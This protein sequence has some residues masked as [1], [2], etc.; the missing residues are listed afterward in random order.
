MDGAAVGLGK[1]LGTC[2]LLTYLALAL[3]YPKFQTMEHPSLASQG[4]TTIA[5]P[6]LVGGGGR[7]VGVTKGGHGV[8]GFV[9]RRLPWIR[10]SRRRR[11]SEMC[12][13]STTS[14][15]AS[16]GRRSGQRA[17]RGGSDGN[18]ASVVGGGA[19][20]V[21]GRR[22]VP[23]LRAGGNCGGVTGIRGNGL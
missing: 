1:I 3:G 16:S 9:R 6:L 10:I 22:A 8:I 13:D 23:V 11:R 15:G 20:V 7:G 14:G 17:G 18:E 5:D 4:S 12:P 19:M 21:G 2:W